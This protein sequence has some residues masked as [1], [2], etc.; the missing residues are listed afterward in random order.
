MLTLIDIYMLFFHQNKISM[1][2]FFV[3]LAALIAMAS[4][5][6][7]KEQKKFIEDKERVIHIDTLGTRF[8]VLITNNN[9]THVIMGDSLFRVESFTG[10]T[11]S[12]DRMLF[13]GFE[14]GLFIEYIPD[15]TSCGEKIQWVNNPFNSPSPAAKKMLRIISPTTN[16]HW[17]MR[18]EIEKIFGFPI[19]DYLK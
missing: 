19:K 13:G 4:S 15:S 2:R 5:C 18:N 9:I 16:L 1:L 14:K 7:K 8:A 12:C 3:V 11:A 10:L 17:L 6:Q